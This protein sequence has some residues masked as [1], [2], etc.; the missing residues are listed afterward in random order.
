MVF[1]EAFGLQGRQPVL[2][3]KSLG[4]ILMFFCSDS[5]V[6]DNLDILRNVGAILSHVT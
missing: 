2:M 4:R 1:L 3:D 5:D 6:S